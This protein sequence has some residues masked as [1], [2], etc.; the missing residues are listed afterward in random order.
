MYA[1]RSYYAKLLAEL[2]QEGRRMLVGTAI[3][4]WVYRAMPGAGP[5]QTWWFID[6]LGFDQEFLSVLS[7]IS[8]G[9]TL[10][11]MFI[12]RRFMAEKSIAL[13]LPASILS[14]SLF[15]PEYTPG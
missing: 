15:T 9:L 13:P 7:L 14:S 1:I 4:I 10:A 11:G 6:V 8:S 3:I 12:F 5:S 2:D